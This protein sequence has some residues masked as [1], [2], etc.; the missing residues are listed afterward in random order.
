MT[1]IVS[2]CIPEPLCVRAKKLGINLSE[3]SRRALSDEVLKFEKQTRS[4][5]TTAENRAVASVKED[6]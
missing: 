2:V 6:T 4:T 1:H 5:P 3:V